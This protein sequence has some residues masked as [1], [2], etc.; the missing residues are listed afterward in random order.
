[1]LCLIKI[2]AGTLKY[3]FNLP[4]TEHIK[5]TC[6]A[7]FSLMSNFFLLLNVKVTTKK[8]QKEKR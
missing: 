8:I 1:M 7:I 6:D 4:Q 5:Q 2:L 3:W